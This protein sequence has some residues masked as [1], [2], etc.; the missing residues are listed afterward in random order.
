[1]MFEM[2]VWDLAKSCSDED[3]PACGAGLGVE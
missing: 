1:M 3:R 2:T